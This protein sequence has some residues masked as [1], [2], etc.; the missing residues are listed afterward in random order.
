MTVVEFLEAAGVLFLSSFI[1]STVGFAAA[2]FAIPLLVWIG[3]DLPE[4]IAAA[5]G[6]TLIQSG[7]GVLLLRRHVRWKDALTASVL[8]LAC[9][10]LGILLLRQLAAQDAAHVK[11]MVGVAL[12]GLVI[13][14]WIFKITPRESLHRGWMVLAFSVSGILVGS[15]GMGGAPSVLW[16][17]A[18]RWSNRELRAFLFVIGFIMAPVH[19]LLLYATFGSSIAA[20]AGAGIL[21]TPLL[22]VGSSLGIRFG[23]TL[24][25]PLLRTTAYA[26]LLVI[27]GASIVQGF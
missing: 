23:N 18:H 2:M 6:A 14:Q 17:M 3:F 19:L 22:L 10:P 24:P 25:R 5:A 16:A 7:H 9:L 12:F 27:S 8:R 4:A 15:V 1:Q 21:A 26:I 20:A 13:S 11:L